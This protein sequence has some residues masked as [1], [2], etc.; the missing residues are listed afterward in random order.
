MQKVEDEILPD[1]SNSETSD[2]EDERPKKKRKKKK[3]VCNIAC[4]PT[5][6]R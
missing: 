6:T 5:T 3:K 1:Q 4:G 2:E